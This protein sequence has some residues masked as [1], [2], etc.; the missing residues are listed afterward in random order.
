MM[1]ISIAMMVKL[2]KVMMMTMT[3]KIEE[4][5]SIAASKVTEH[6]NYLGRPSHLFSGLRFPILG[7]LQGFSLHLGDLLRQL[8]TTSRSPLQDLFKP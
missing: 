6:R 2:M 8:A 3:A 7:R 1:M 4:V 5:V